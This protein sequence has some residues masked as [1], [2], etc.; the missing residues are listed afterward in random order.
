MKSKPIPKE[1]R[2]APLIRNRQTYQFIVRYPHGAQA[3]NGYRRAVR[4]FGFYTLSDPTFAG[5][6]AFRF[7]V[8]KDRRIPAKTAKAIL[9]K[10]AKAIVK[11][12]EE[13]SETWLVEEIETFDKFKVTTFEDDWC[14]W[15]HEDNFWAVKSLG[16]RPEVVELITK[17]S[18]HYGYRITITKKS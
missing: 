6:D 5:N 3:N 4:H 13:M 12:G 7:F 11:I 1:F 14:Q 10:T 2:N 9:R 17:K 8:C 15:S 18:G 16:L